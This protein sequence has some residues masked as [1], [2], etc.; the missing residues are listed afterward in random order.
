MR[1]RNLKLVELS[2]PG[3]APLLGVAHTLRHYAEYATVC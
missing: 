3:E 2:A 1:I